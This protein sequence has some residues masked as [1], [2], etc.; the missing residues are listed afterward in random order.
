M[1]LLQIQ[2]KIL[3]HLS[4]PV[5]FHCVSQKEF[6]PYW[7]LSVTVLQGKFSRSYD[8]LSKCDCYVV[9]KLPTACACCHRTKTVKNSDAPKWNETFRFRVIRPLHCTQFLKWLT[10]FIG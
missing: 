4:K 6:M 9:L 3:L 8:L 10:A 7:N 1:L 5:S 2:M